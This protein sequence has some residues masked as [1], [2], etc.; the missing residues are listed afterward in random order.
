M[1]IPPGEILSDRH[2]RCP[3]QHPVSHSGFSANAGEGWW[4]TITVIIIAS[5]I[6]AV[7]W[8]L[9]ALCVLTLCVLTTT[10]WDRCCPLLQ[11]G[12]LRLKEAGYSSKAAQLIMGPGRQPGIRAPNL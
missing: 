4:A 3:V 9:K 12:K 8:A 7:Y 5:T 1:K 6:A 10:L 2:P 11:M